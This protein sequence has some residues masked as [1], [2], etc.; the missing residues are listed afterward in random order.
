MSTE[1]G[2][3][4]TSPKTG[5]E[6]FCTDEAFLDYTLKDFWIWS[7]SDLVS[8]A[9]R[10]RLAEF[11]VA[12]ALGIATNV[13]RDEWEAFD[14]KTP[15]GKKIEVKS[16][17]YIQSWNQSKLSSIIFSTRKTRYWDSRTNIQEKESK[18]QADVYVFAL[19]ANQEKKTIN[20]L[21]VKQWE[22]Y[23]MSTKALG[24]Y[25]RSDV[26]ITLNSLKGL[27]AGPVD[28]FGL[29]GRVGDALA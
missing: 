18:R 28:Y 21:N 5:G 24:D 11:I 8:N 13:A 12:K 25:K 29:A 9:T 14:L 20:P 7:V 6:R 3:L 27:K 17:A 15:A 19:L 10:G 1:L 4:A 16:A 2:P 26:S 23:V 22:F